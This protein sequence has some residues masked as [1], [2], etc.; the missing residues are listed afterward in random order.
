MPTCS[1]HQNFFSLGI[2]NSI[3]F[4]PMILFRFICTNI[5]RVRNNFVVDTIISSGWQLYNILYFHLIFGYIYSTFAFNMLRN[6][7]TSNMKF[8]QLMGQIDL[9]LLV[10]SPFRRIGILANPSLHDITIECQIFFISDL[11][12][13]SFQLLSLS[14]I[15]TILIYMAIEIV[16]T[17]DD[18]TNLD[19]QNGR[20]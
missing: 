1:S 13:I 18:T 20:L 15:I 12:N 4:F 5:F 3:I 14:V 7:N 19:L 9:Y 10:R 8:F 6:F 16:P 2:V 17:F 11:L